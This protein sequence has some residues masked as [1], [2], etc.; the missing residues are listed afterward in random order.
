M[1]SRQRSSQVYTI[2]YYGAA[3]VCAIILL[4][5]FS[6][7]LGVVGSYLMRPFYSIRVWIGDSM[8]PVSSFFT[9]RAELAREIEDLKE[10]MNTAIYD[11]QRLKVLEEEILS[12]RKESEH[13]TSRILADVVRHPN[14][15]PYDTIVL[16]RGQDGGIKESAFVYVH[17]VPI[18]TVARVFSHSSIVVL[19]STPDIETPVFIHGARVFARAEGQGGGVLRVSVP[20]G[21]PLTVGDVVTVPVGNTD[22]YGEIAYIESVPSNPEQYGFIV[23]K[24]ALSS[25]RTVSVEKDVTEHIPYEDA[26]AILRDARAHSTSSALGILS[27]ELLKEDVLI[28]P[29]LLGTT[30]ST[31][32]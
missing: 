31:T 28:I 24:E 5:F 7:P 1:N 11:A 15:T 13:G 8:S 27:E 25:L 21:V 18:G 2:R 19:F 12:L 10:D 29:D 4:Y 26:V 20:Q 3:F 17:N 6:A 22:I 16:N 14:D 32:P 23:Q 30:S 9:T